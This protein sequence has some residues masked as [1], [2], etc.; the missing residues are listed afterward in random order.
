M[1][2]V[3]FKVRHYKHGVNDNTFTPG[4]KSVRRGSLRNLTSH[5]KTFF[6]MDIALICGSL[7][8]LGPYH[9]LLEGGES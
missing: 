5:N 2:L 4:F 9:A 6:V 3:G 8:L 7:F 1:V